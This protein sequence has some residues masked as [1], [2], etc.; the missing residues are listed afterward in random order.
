[1]PRKRNVRH[2]K[3]GNKASAVTRDRRTEMERYKD[4]VDLKE[5][6]RRFNKKSREHVEKCKDRNCPVKTYL[7]NIA[8]EAKRKVERAN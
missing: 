5:D 2:E 1:M 6:L 4:Y 3:L 7:E 8:S